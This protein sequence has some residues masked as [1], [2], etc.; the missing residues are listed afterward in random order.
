MRR[1]SGVRR[2]Q[3]ESVHERNSQ[4][5][6]KYL[7]HKKKNSH[8]NSTS[9]LTM[10]APGKSRISGNRVAACVTVSSTRRCS[11][12]ST[13]SIATPM[14][15]L[16][17]WFYSQWLPLP[18]ELSR[19]CLESLAA[20]TI[21]IEVMWWTWTPTKCGR[22]T[23]GN[24]SAYFRPATEHR[25]INYGPR[26]AI[27]PIPATGHRSM[28]SYAAKSGNPKGLSMQWSVRGIA[29]EKPIKSGVSKRETSS[30]TCCV[31]HLPEEQQ[32]K[33]VHRMQYRLW[34]E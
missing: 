29:K 8:T 6:D 10:D 31:R 25:Q 12:N 28:H 22:P 2:P 26:S 3:K 27:R 30:A 20:R 17:I 11:T 18:W 14:L 4:S 7:Q 15:T 32:W 5:I 1:S 16:T 19:K 24:S 23:V 13:L 9:A 33:R 34:F 21:Q